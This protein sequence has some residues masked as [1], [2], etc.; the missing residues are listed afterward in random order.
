MARAAP[1]ASKW[2]VEICSRNVQVV[3]GPESNRQQQ[4]GC[5][6][7]LSTGRAWGKEGQSSWGRKVRA[8]R[9]GARP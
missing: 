6:G 3:M 9:A 7:W 1:W 4:R 2:L 5:R 8:R